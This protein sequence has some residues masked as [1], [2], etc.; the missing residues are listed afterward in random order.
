M[1]TILLIH[2]ALLLISDS[3]V[4]G[5]TSGVDSSATYSRFERFEKY[6]AFGARYDHSGNE[7]ADFGMDM[8]S[9]QTLH[10]G[11]WTIEQNVFTLSAVQRDDAITYS[12]QGPINLL[13]Y[14]MAW[15]ART[16]GRDAS[17]VLVTPAFVLLTAPSSRYSFAVSRSFIVA[18]NNNTEY[19]F[20]RGH[21][22]TRGITY[23]PSLTVTFRRHTPGA[24]SFDFWG[25]SVHAG[26]TLFWNFEGADRVEGFT[27]GV[28]LNFGYIEYW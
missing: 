7:Y 20:I 25:V 26:T 18:L 3:V 15:L 28:E 8:S 9:G 5:A 17:D 14:S 10:R 22:G 6:G 13:V 16:D 23:T 1:K 19:V 2:F 12:A 27:V 4:A 21:L 11:R 24:E